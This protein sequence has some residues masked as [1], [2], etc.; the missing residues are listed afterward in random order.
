VVAGTHLVV[1]TYLLAGPPVAVDWLTLA[2]PPGAPDLLADQ[3]LAG[4][5]YLLVPLLALTPVA[6]RLGA[7]ARASQMASR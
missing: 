5:V 3:R 4:A 1:G 7:R 6:V 2:A